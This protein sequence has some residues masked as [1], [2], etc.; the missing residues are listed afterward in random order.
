[1]VKK[2]KQFFKAFKCKIQKKLYSL[3]LNYIKF[4][5]FVK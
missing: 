5:V 2:L 1:M 4:M 3:L